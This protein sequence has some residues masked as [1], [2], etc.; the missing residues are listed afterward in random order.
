MS[1]DRNQVLQFI[2]IYAEALIRWRHNGTVVPPD[3]FLP[4]LDKQQ[5]WDLTA[6]CIRRALREMHDLNCSLPIAV[7]LDATIVARP[8]FPE[9]VANELRLW[10]IAPDRLA[11]EI[12]ETA[13]I[14]NYEATTAILSGLRESGHT[15]AIDDYGTGQATLQHFRRLPTNEIKIDKQFIT[16]VVSGPNDREIVENI[17]QLARRCDKHVIAEG[18]E[19]ARTLEYLIEQG[20]DAGQGYYLA[21]PMSRSQFASLF[22]G[23]EQP[24][25]PRVNEG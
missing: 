9:F 4:R 6:F 21:M 20:C 3:E 19:A 16:N 23:T 7:N 22:K 11:F 15:I 14:D 18:I 1:A 5:I 2:C 24:S 25:S 17:L 13:A 10:G 8:E 12:T